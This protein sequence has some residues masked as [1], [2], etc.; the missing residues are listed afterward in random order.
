M[1]LWPGG[2]LSYSQARVC[3]HIVCEGWAGVCVCVCVC[4]CVDK[5]SQLFSP[6]M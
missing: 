4:V 1:C 3:A 6:H 2:A 5:V